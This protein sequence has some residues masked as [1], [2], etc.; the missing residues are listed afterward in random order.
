MDEMPRNSI[1]NQ[2][3]ENRKVV[4]PNTQLTK[5]QKRARTEDQEE[6]DEDL[7]DAPPQAPVNPAFANQMR[8]YPNPDLSKRFRP[9]GAPNPVFVPELPTAKVVPIGTYALDTGNQRLVFAYVSTK[10]DLMYI[11]RNFTRI[12]IHPN[13]LL[14]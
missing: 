2:S 8:T 11:P 4:S 6:S 12:S 5:N 1:P 13:V 10:G 7:G 14:P 3:P 9:F